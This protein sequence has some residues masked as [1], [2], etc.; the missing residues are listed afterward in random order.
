M[1]DIIKKIPIMS[2]RLLK[3]PGKE[4]GIIKPYLSHSKK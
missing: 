4:L 3:A 1:Q 2:F